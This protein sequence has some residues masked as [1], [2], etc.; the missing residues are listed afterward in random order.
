VRYEDF[1]NPHVAGRQTELLLTPAG[2]V[3]IADQLA[4]SQFQ[5]NASGALYASAKNNWSFRSGFSYSL[6]KSGRTLVRAAYGI[7]YDRPFDNYWFPLE[8]NPLLRALS[9]DAG[10]VDY[11]KPVAANLSQ[12]HN[13]GYDVTNPAFLTAFS[14]FIRNARIQSYFAGIQQEITH[15]L[16]VEADALG[17]RGINLI[18]TDQINRVDSVKPVSGSNPLG[19]INPAL[20][21][22]M[23][24]RDSNGR[25]RYDGLIIQARM[26]AARGQF[27]LAYT[28]S[29]S[30][31]HQ[32]DPLS[33][34]FLNLDFTETGVPGSDK[35]R[36]FFTI[37]FHPESD[38]GRSDF[39]QHHNLVFY[40]LWQLPE[41]HG[42]ALWSRLL[43][44]WSFSQM[45]AIRSGLPFSVI[46]CTDNLSA[47]CSNIGALMHNRADLVLPES[48]FQPQ[49]TSG[50]V[51]LLNAAAFGT[52]SPGVLGN[53]ARNQFTGPGFWS[54][55]LSLSREFRLSHSKETLRA[56][57]RADAF[58]IFNHANLNNPDSYL[59]DGDQFGV[60]LYGRSG[61]SAA[62][63]NLVPFDEAAR[64]VQ[65]MLRIQ[66]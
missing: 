66:F 64:Q 20:P 7:Y 16:S 9:A 35:P 29:R 34:D 27:H 4:T 10:P 49:R 40:S 54:M 15:N 65:L 55:D 45:S 56:L 14:P 37:Q 13:I 25:S 19:L 21:E 42:S 6:S 8:A 47:A 5:A 39:D 43:G 2:G 52:P 33:G 46:A 44:R 12:F 11:L 53:T 58:N 57:V 26:R 23:F 62:F 24:Y 1:G 60:A 28:L 61:N 18:T 31:D 48:V 51:K 22:Q 17:S 36:P 63:P 41:L 59:Q 32:S 3:P 38:W 30:Y 50:G